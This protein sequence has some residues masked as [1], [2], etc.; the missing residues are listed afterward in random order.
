MSVDGTI[1]LPKV[2]PANIDSAS[3]GESH[4]FVG[5]DGNLR[6][7]DEAGAVKVYG[8]AVSNHS[9][10]SNLSADDHLQYH[11]DTRGDAR[12]YTKTANDLLLA[13]KLDKTDDILTTQNIVKVKLNP[14]TGEFSSIAAAAASILDSSATNPYVIK[15]GPGEYTE[16]VINLPAYVSVEGESIQSTIILPST[17]TQHLFVLNTGCELSFMSMVG[18]LGAGKAAIYIVDVGDF[19]QTHKLS[20][21]DFDIGI[22]HKATAA[23]SFFYA[24]YVDINGN[25]TY[26]VQA[27]SEN[28]FANR[29]NLENF[30][31]YESTASGAIS[32]YGTG[33]N[34]ELQLFSSKLFCESTQKGISTANGV[35]LRCNGVDVQ[36]ASTAIEI[37]N[38]GIGGAIETLATA[39]K[40]N[41]LDYAILH[42]SATGSIFGG[43]NKDKI[44]IDPSATVSVLILD[45]VNEGII[46]NG[47]MYYSFDSYGNITDISRLI[48]SA[49]TMGLIQ[50]GELT[51]GTGLSV[52][53]AAGFGYL[54]TGTYPNNVLKRIDWVSGSVSLSANQSAFVYVNSSGSLVA[55][56]ARPS[57]TSF[58]LLGRVTTDASAVMYIEAVSLDAHHYSNKA[59]RILRE[60]I[61]PVYHTGSLVA[62]SGTRQL[63]VTAGEY[64]FGEHE[65]NLSGGSPITF[66]VFYRSAV[67]GIYTKIANQTTVTNTQYD[68]GTGTLASITS[69]KHVKHLLIAVGNPVEKYLLVLGQAEYNSGAEAQSA[70]LPIVPSFV[71]ESF[72]NIASIVVSQNATN[73]HSIIDERPRIGFASSSVTGAITSHSGLT[74]LG[75]DDHLQYIR[76]DGTRAFTGSQSFGGNNITSVGT[77]NGVT[78]E[79]HAS[80]HLPN[81]ADP[82]TTGAPSSIGSANSEGTANALARQDHVHAHGDQGRGTQHQNATTSE[83][84]FMSSTDKIKLDGITNDVFYKQTTQLT[85]SSS[86]VFTN[87]TDAGFPV[88]AGSVYR[89]RTWILYRSTA[90]TNGI[91]LAL[92]T[93]RG[94]TGTVSSRFFNNTSAASASITVVVNLNT[95]VTA[96]N[97]PFTTSDS[98]CE[99][100]GIFI[101]TASG[102]LVPQFRAKVNGN[103]ITVQPNTFTEVKVI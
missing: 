88:V 57:T 87:I 25:F 97:S 73:F 62:E 10:L 56:T 4:L 83:S 92:T 94:A 69:N 54:M 65:I 61:G 5:T 101:C 30:Y 9:L 24:E 39:F 34:L 76:S 28:G 93:T 46:L 3:T 19:T 53:V 58:I 95:A 77:I 49:P 21:Y 55:N 70:G 26:A 86:T 43:S 45:T 85:N 52:N 48:T 98:L 22:Y 44:S 29:T 40:N 38:S 68:D 31:T 71:S 89:F 1:A 102:N 72:V 50:G 15:V 78:V 96:A 8:E 60:A 36:G 14:S 74:D 80:R 41:T 37:Q 17:N 51:S 59:D 90:T 42:P 66:D 35:V 99:I 6:S 67:P 81:G 82:L 75:N 33:T 84:G 2:N 91:V 32:V 23:E 11:N 12:Y 64:Y 16:P 63:N 100:E 20:I 27:I 7:K 79:T 13:D 103:T 18:L 47:P